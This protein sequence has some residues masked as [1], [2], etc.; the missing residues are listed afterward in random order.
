[1]TQA[2]A[3]TSFERA[4]VSS[5]CP[6]VLTPFD[7]D[8][9]DFDLRECFGFGKEQLQEMLPQRVDLTVVED[10]LPAE[11]FVVPLVATESVLS[12]D[13]GTKNTGIVVVNYETEEVLHH[14]VAAIAFNRAT[15]CDENALALC[16]KLEQLRAQFNVKHFVYERQVTGTNLLR[17][18]ASLM[19]LGANWKRSGAISDCKTVLPKQSHK[20]WDF[21]AKSNHRTNKK[22]AEA[23]F[24]HKAMGLH[25]CEYVNSM[26]KAHEKLDDIA[27][28][29][30]NAVFYLRN[31]K[32]N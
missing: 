13:P 2:Y 12:V 1:M 32:S 8:E 7:D 4:G 19:M 29:Y 9:V 26:L 23:L 5:R 18:E 15:S 20:F 11:S 31:T 22:H 16:D 3:S 28:A 6:I 27:D 14:E 17:I 10:V 30:L 25:S 21:P 24:I